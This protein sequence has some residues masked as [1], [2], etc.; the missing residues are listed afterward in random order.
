MLISESSTHAV[1]SESSTHAVKCQ[2]AK[3][4]LCSMW[5]CI[6]SRPVWLSFWLGDVVLWCFVN[7]RLQASCS[8]L[9]VSSSGFLKKAIAHH[10]LSEAAAA[11]LCR[12]GDSGSTLFTLLSQLEDLCVVGQAYS[13]L[14]NWMVVEWREVVP[15]LCGVLLGLRSCY[16]WLVTRTCC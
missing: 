7:P 14:L 9:P 8:R 15:Y 10:E 5:R 13:H 2:F 16:I 1:I 3:H 6:T 11:H 4:I 12:S